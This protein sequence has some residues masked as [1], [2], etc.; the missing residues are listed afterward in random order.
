LIR[1]LFLIDKLHRAGAQVQLALLAARLDRSRFQ[2]EVVTLQENGP[3]ADSLQAAGVPVSSLGLRRL[4]GPRGVAAFHALARRLRASRVDVLHTYLVSANVYGALAGRVAGVP[5]I[6]TSRRDTGFSRNWRLRLVEE[7]LVNPKVDRVVA[8][9]EAAAAAARRERGLGAE[10]VLTIE[11]GVDLAAWDPAA[12]DAA[13]A[14]RDL[15]LPAEAPV[16]GVIANLV[17]VKGHSDFLRAA[18]L[19][20][21]RLPAARFLLVGSGPL[22]DSLENQ[23]RA[24]GL[25]DKVVFAGPR[26][27]VARALAALDLLVVAS[28]T[29]GLSNVLLEAMA[30][31]RPVLATRVGG[32]PAVVQ[33]CE[34]GRLVPPA[35]PTALGAAMLEMLE[36]RS[37]SLALGRRARAWVAERFSAGQMVHRHEQLYESLV[38]SRR[39]AAEAQPA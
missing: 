37:R 1:V 8:V 7:W 20:G 35:D 31:G 17:P 21:A 23:A 3:L 9:S 24:L 15:G 2:P 16:A 18:A 26:D 39:S 11:N 28:H 25:G 10:R 14:R 19:V 33:D 4:Y 6:V 27:D 29:E 30:M 34:T 32:N 36:D 22:R 5:A 38:A 12:H 13:L